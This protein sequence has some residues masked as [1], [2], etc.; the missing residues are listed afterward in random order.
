M[1]PQKVQNPQMTSCETSHF[2]LETSQRNGLQQAAPVSAWSAPLGRSPAWPQAPQGSHDQL[3]VE[4]IVCL[5]RK[6]FKDL[7]SSV[8]YV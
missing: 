1:I 3:M 2:L 7:V 6:K 4:I 8:F 5:D